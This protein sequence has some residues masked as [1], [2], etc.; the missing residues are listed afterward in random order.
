MKELGDKDIEDILC[1]ISPLFGKYGLVAVWLDESESVKTGKPE[2]RFLT[3]DEPEARKSYGRAI[4]LAVSKIS[5]DMGDKAKRH[6][7]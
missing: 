2:F 6:K 7:L 5:T 1:Y 4:S 3:M